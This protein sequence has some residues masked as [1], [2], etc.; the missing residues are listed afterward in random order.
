MR[1]PERAVMHWHHPAGIQI[2][3]GAGGVAG[4]GMDIP[5]RRG[6]VRANRKQRDFGPQALANVAEPGEISGVSGVV[7]RMLIVAQH[8]PAVAAM[9]I[10]NNAG[11]PVSRWDVSDRQ[12]AM[13]VAVPPVELNDVFESQVGHEIKN[14]MWDDNCR[15]FAA[16][17]SML[18]DP[19]QRRPVQMVE[20]R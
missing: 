9:R 7:D 8:V 6:I 4:I 15:Q 2:E 3:E 13:A 17:S 20:V 12:T 19:P 11:S 18:H 1:Q 10:L 14:M 5:K 16:P